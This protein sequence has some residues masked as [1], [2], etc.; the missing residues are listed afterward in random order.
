MYL[1][2]LYPK[3]DHYW[4]SVKIWNDWLDTPFYTHNWSKKWI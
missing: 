2:G 1:L 3:F 4:N